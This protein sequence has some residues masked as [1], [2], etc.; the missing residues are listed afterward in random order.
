M[1]GKL[2]DSSNTIAYQCVLMVL[3]ATRVADRKNAQHDTKQPQNTQRS[4]HVLLGDANDDGLGLRH[5]ARVV[6]Q[7]SQWCPPRQPQT[8][9]LGDILCCAIKGG[10]PVLACLSACLH[11]SV[12]LCL[13]LSVSLCLSV[14]RSINTEG[15]MSHALCT[16]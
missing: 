12:C 3:F 11:L 2:H 5:A 4:P 6:T 16:V 7:A 10:H 8:T 9:N 1:H 13:S 15:P 14:S